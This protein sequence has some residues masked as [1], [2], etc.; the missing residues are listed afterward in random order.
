MRGAEPRNWT[1]PR[2][3]VMRINMLSETNLKKYTHRREADLKLCASWFA[4]TG[5]NLG[6]IFG[7]SEQEIIDAAATAPEENP[8]TTEA[9]DEIFV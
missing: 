3:Q 2:I 6:H 7:F 5:E 1:S 4:L 9:L 8:Q